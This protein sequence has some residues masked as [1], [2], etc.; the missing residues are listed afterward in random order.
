[1]KTIKLNAEAWEKSEL[2]PGIIAPDEEWVIEQLDNSTFLTH[3]RRYDI[4]FHAEYRNGT[5]FY[6]I[7]YYDNEK[8]RFYHSSRFFLKF[9]RLVREITFFLLQENMLWDIQNNC[10]AL[11]TY[12]NDIRS[13][14]Q[15]CIKKNMSV[16]KFLKN[17]FT[18][19]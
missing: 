1:M 15:N 18:E 10:E 7:K 14:Y 6:I 2:F 9:I 3:N 12:K 5:H 16:S 17:L 4:Y 11:K 13:Y 19:I 8:K